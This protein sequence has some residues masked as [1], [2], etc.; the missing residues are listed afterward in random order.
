MSE[1][2]IFNKLLG[3]RVLVRRFGAKDDA[4]FVDEQTVDEVS[5]TGGWVKMSATWQ[6]VDTIRI[7]EVLP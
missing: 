3:K 2:A 7:V 6:R 4:L 1:A 5:P